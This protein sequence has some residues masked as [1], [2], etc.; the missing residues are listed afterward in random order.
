MATLLS[1]TEI[2]QGA[3][4]D[5]GTQG[6]RKYHRVFRLE[7]DGPSTGPGK[8]I[9]DQLVK[10]YDSYEEP[11]GL[12]DRAALAVSASAS[13]EDPDVSFNWLATVYY[14]TQWW[15]E[16]ARNQLSGG[17]GTTGQPPGGGGGGAGDNSPANP[18]ARPWKYRF[19]R[20]PERLIM[21]RDYDPDTEE[22]K[23]IIVGTTAGI[24]FDPPLETERGLR[25]ITIERNTIT[26]DPLF[27]ATFE[28]TVNNVD[29]TIGQR[30]YSAESLKCESWTADTEG[31]ENG[32]VYFA[33]TI[34]LIHKL[35]K[36]IPNHNPPTRSRWR[37]IMRNAGLQEKKSGKI[38]DIMRQGSA[39]SKPWP[40][41]PQGQAL[42]ENYLDADVYYRQFIE[43]PPKDWSGMNIEDKG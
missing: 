14:T 31:P 27:A 8:A 11:G 20:V 28:D 33:E 21:E 16:V 25:T 2:S 38:K 1:I 4:V 13:A 42:A 36:N 19:G 17:T 7:Y 6:E 43:F 12:E 5:V 30:T 15:D 35:G 32:V 3:D 10:R 41:D 18:L 26:Y 24:P 40:L 29:I 23:G 22:K 39:V 37:R 34:I 9:L